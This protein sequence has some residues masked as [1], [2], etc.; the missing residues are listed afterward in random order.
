MSIIS[1]VDEVIY[2]YEILKK[3]HHVYN[4]GYLRDVLLSDNYVWLDEQSSTELA[5][6]TYLLSKRFF[7]GKKMV[8]LVNM[9]STKSSI[10]S[11]VSIRSVMN[12][13][14]YKD[15]EG[16]VITDQIFERCLAA[17]LRFL[18]ILTY[19]QPL[20]T[21]YNRFK[22]VIDYYISNKITH[23]DISRVDNSFLE[24]SILESKEYFLRSLREEPEKWAGVNGIIWTA[25]YKDNSIMKMVFDNLPYNEE[26]VLAVSQRNDSDLYAFGNKFSPKIIERKTFRIY[27]VGGPFYGQYSIDHNA[28]Y[29]RN[30]F[31]N[32][33]EEVIHMTLS[34]VF[35]PSRKERESIR[36]SGL[37]LLANLI[38]KQKVIK[39]A[40]NYSSPS[41]NTL[42]M[43][44]LNFMRSFEY[45]KNIS[46]YIAY[47]EE[48]KVDF[49]LYDNI[50][51]SQ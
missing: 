2:A 11:N 31:N 35:Y 27:I 51:S 22:M 16:I 7:D 47:I 4:L 5:D 14:S 30:E 9:L 28:S 10:F 38:Q 49:L 21:S 1:E 34:K 40:K 46:L 8:E 13:K 19:Q 25:R 15:A 17:D 48:Y 37:E 12:I 44:K 50:F 36:E 32:R 33:Y 42:E 20:I 43:W 29:V 3:D 18:D 24:Y 23:D 26:V 41:V 39:Q 6:T 45:H